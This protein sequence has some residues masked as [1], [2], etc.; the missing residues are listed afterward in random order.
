MTDIS[1]FEMR[2]LNCGLIRNPK[3]EIRNQ[4][5]L[6]GLI[7]F[8]FL[9]SCKKDEV[10][11]TAGPAYQYAP[12]DT[13]RWILYDVDSTYYSVFTT[14]PAT[15]FTF[16]ILERIDSTYIDNQGRP[17]QRLQRFKRN[18]ASAPW[19]PEV[20][21]WNSTLTLARYERVENNVRYVKLGFPINLNTTWNGN[22]YNFFGED[23]Y[24]Y[25]D[26][27]VQYS[28]GTFYFDSTLIVLRG[29]LPNAI[30]RKNGK[31]IFAN[32]VGM[33]YKEYY[34][35]DIQNFSDTTGAKYFYSI[36]AHGLH[37]ASVP[38]PH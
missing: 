13:G 28:I 2:I 26:V 17:T 22:A 3:S 14:P 16:Q 21:V 32:H 38:I 19:Q 36:A 35:L 30:E 11:R 5:F 31:E 18:S 34:D 24:G 10:I 27:H 9:S 7:L 4:Y 25:D 1:N 33:I 20:N 6:V 15:R 23:I 12:I 29:P 37:N 8:L